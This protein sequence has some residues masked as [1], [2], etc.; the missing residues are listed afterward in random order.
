M[1]DTDPT[2]HALVAFNLSGPQAEE[3]RLMAVDQI[4]DLLQGLGCRAI[5][6]EICLGD[7]KA[8]TLESPESIKVEEVL[9]A[10]IRPFIDDQGLKHRTKSSLN[11]YLGQHGVKTVLD[12]LAL[13]SNFFYSERSRNVSLEQIGI[14][15]CALERAGVAHLWQEEPTMSNLAEFCDSINGVTARVIGDSGRYLSLTIGE[16]LAMNGT[17]LQEYIDKAYTLHSAADKPVAK[18]VLS[19]ARAYRNRFNAIKKGREVDESDS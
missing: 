11:N 12:V 16:I 3:R 19:K 6:I 17:E 18:M 9:G 15:R 14:I 7:G 2:I 8:P 5:D 1:S 13:G 10:R 4:Q